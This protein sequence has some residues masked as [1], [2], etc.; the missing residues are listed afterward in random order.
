MNILIIEQGP[1]DCMMNLMAGLIKNNHR[2]FVFHMNAKSIASIQEKIDLVITQSWIGVDPQGQTAFDDLK[3]PILN[4]SF[5]NSIQ[6][7]TGI[8]GFDIVTFNKMCKSRHIFNWIMCRHMEREYRKLGFANSVYAPWGTS[9]EKAILLHRDPNRVVFPHEISLLNSEQF[10]EAQRKALLSSNLLN[11]AKYDIKTILFMGVSPND[12]SMKGS[13]D[14]RLIGI[15][16]SEIDNVIGEYK[17][18]IID[19]TSRMEFAGRLGIYKEIFSAPHT[20]N[21]FLK[22]NQLIFLYKRAMLKLR[23][24]YVKSLFDCYGDDFVIY[25]DGWEQEGV[26]TFPSD[27]T[28]RNILYAY[29][30]I[31]LDLGSL[32]YETAIYPRPMQV[33]SNGGYIFQFRNPLNLESNDRLLNNSFSNTPDEMIEKIDCMLKDTTF[34]QSSKA[35]QSKYFYEKYNFSRV[36]EEMFPF[37]LS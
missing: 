2:L 29:F 12:V 6:E 8:S 18:D 7:L 36:F 5:G 35:L 25:G 26:K 20:R 30:P 27:G 34:Y 24:S 21:T 11:S 23:K 28:G 9:R 31:T 37:I 15:S 4:I 13:L 19:G 3:C 17:D 32:S 16:K 10:V 14:T 33:V 1:L 22:Y